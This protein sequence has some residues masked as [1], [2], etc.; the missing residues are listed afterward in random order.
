ML[1]NIPKPC[2]E[3]WA[4][5]TPDTQGRFCSSCQKTVVDFTHM[6]DDAVKNYLLDQR[7]QNTCGR[8]LT[9]Q[10]GR[11]LEN[12]AVSINRQWYTQLPFARQVFYAFALFFVLGASSCSWETKGEP[13]VMQQGAPPDT[14][15]MTAPMGEA[16]YRD[17]AANTPA[18]HK[19]TITSVQPVMTGDIAVETG[20]PEWTPEPD[21]TRMI[22]GKI[23]M[24]AP[25]TTKPEPMIMGGISLPSNPLPDSTSV[26]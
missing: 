15:T 12:Q 8:F 14:I 25:D 10:L 6:S 19:I 22:T 16:V 17:S 20:I 1:L 11:P 7:H 23:A 13:Q 18:P 5:M 9:S 26:K 24:P 3:S 4:E 21:T 2:H